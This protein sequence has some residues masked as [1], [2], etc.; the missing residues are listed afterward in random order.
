[1][2]LKISNIFLHLSLPWLVSA[3]IIWEVSADMGILKLD[4][5]KAFD[6]VDQSSDRC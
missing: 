1:M 6:R 5:E 2:T 3:I 4:Q